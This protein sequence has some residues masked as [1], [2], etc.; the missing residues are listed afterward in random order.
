LAW[1]GFSP[2]YTL[3]I[4]LILAGIVFS[5]VQKAR[6]GILS[7]LKDGKWYY[8]LFLLVFSTMLVVRMFHSDIAIG[9]WDKFM[10]HGFIASMMRT[11]VVPPL[12]P[13]FAGGRLDVYYYLGHWC[14]ATLGVISHIPSWILFQFVA[15]TVASV[16]AVQLYGIGK[17][18]LKKFSLLPV[19]LLF[20]TNPAFINDYL[21][22]V[23]LFYL[24]SS[25]VRVIPATFTEYPLYTFLHGDAHAHA[26]GVFN[27]TF[28]ILLVVYLFTKWQKLINSERVL[29]VILAGISLGTMAG[30]NAWNLF[31]YGPLFVLA[32]IV[33]W[34]Q[35]HRGA[36][37]EEFS[38]V[39]TWISRIC[40]HFCH[41]VSSLLKKGTEISHSSGAILY[42]WILVPLIALL[43]YA[44]FFLMMNP[45]GAQGIGIVYS[46]T[47]VPEFFLAF[48]WF[49]VLLLCTL[50][51]DI[52]KHPILIVIAIPFIIAG[53][54]LIG[55]ILVLLAYLV[56]R[57]E[58][59]SDFLFACGL[60]LA[61]LCELV[62]I[63]DSTNWGEW[64]RLNT[65]WK[66]YAAAWLLLGV[67]A[68]ASASIRVEQFMDRACHTERGAIIGRYIPKLVV[69]W[70]V[71]LILFAPVVNHELRS[72][73][74]YEIQGIDGFDW[75]KRTNPD[76]YAAAMYLS[77][78][79]G[80]YVLVEAGGNFDLHYTRMSSVTGIPSILG[81]TAHEQSWR[82]DNPPGWVEERISDLS[83]RYE[84]PERT[85]EIMAKYNADFLILGAAERTQ[86]QVPDDFD[87]Y[88][89]DL[90]PVFISGETV[91]YQRVE[92]S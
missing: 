9:P 71:I 86:Y 66:L 56:V 11:P 54:P 51:S 37:G 52:K 83:I 58:G 8:A 40:V 7:D 29:C 21:N 65:V 88:L 70:I 2:A 10:N 44:P 90:E 79:P 39:K 25:S 26:M 30:M 35:T 63:I 49:L 41:D 5:T 59:V 60:L 91:I 13:W 74:Y 46:K 34:Y 31:S 69:G 36:E 17:L 12:D 42:L 62:Y 77:E 75:M 87:A 20:I 18:L 64:Y 22:G 4:F 24:L 45:Y 84:Q 23:S 85:S 27:Q 16:S 32:A 78:L 81:G 48:G 19:I 55:F 38:G 61:L 80:E 67:G 72:V 28:F 14:F 76:D 15:P 43:S 82:G 92:P 50:Y 53:Y 57:H 47:T 73:S 1:L 3:G 68:L 6:I 89:S 33:I